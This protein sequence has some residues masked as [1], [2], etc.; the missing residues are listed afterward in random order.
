[1]K[2]NWEEKKTQKNPIVETDQKELTTH[3]NVIICYG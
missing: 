2:Y 3:I 1:M